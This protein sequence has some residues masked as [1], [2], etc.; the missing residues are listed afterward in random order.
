MKIIINHNNANKTIELKKNSTVGDIIKLMQLEDVLIIKNG[1]IL[2]N[3]DI[4]QENDKLR[5]LPVVSGG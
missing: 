2:S 5:V 4:V 1:E 3:D